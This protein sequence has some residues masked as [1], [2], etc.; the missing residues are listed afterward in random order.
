MKKILLS[1]ILIGSINTFAAEKIKSCTYAVKSPH[2]QAKI[3]KYKTDFFKDGDKVY[4]VVTELSKKTAATSAEGERQERVEQAEY[5]IRQDIQL[6]SPNLNAG[7][8]IILGTQMAIKSPEY[9]KISHVTID[10]NKVAKVK[11]FLTGEFM[12]E[13]AFMF[14]ETF[15]AQNN[16]LGTYVTGLIAPV[17]C[18][19]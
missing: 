10:L 1:T 6:D 11:T 15:D 19:K 17:M 3:E 4:S 7:E 12:G 18:E 13:L 14:V 16:N 5:S 2:D 9:S 8:R